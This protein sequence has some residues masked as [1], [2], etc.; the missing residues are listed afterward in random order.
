[1]QVETKTFESMNGVIVLLATLGLIVGC[2]L[3]GF[4]IDF[5]N[6]RRLV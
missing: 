2:T 6:K 1:M 5:Y 4:A 3:V